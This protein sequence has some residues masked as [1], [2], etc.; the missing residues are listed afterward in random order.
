MI[1]V[2]ISVDVP[3]LEEGLRFY[4]EAFGFIKLAEPFPGVAVL[5]AGDAELLLLAKALGAGAKQERLFE[6]S[7]KPSSRAVIEFS[8]G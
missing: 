3:S 6:N 2:S 8:V 4:A 5:R 1:S 7:G